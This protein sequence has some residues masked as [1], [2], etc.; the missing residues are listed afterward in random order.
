MDSVQSEKGY[1]ADAAAVG[2][3]LVG[4][5]LS[6]T[7]ASDDKVRIR[8]GATQFTLPQIRN[9][10]ARYVSE[11]RDLGLQTGDKALALLDHGPRGLFLISAASA[12]GVRLMMPY[13]IDSAALSEWLSIIRLT[14]PKHVIYQRPDRSIVETLREHSTNLVDLPFHDT[15][16]SDAEVTVDSPEPVSSFLVL[17]SSGTTGTPKAICI[18]EA[19]IVR[20]VASVSR[21]LR[22]TSESTIF[23]TG[24][25]NNT[26]GVL[27]SYGGILRGSS[28]VF[29][30]SREPENWP[31][32]IA[33]SAATHTFL[34]PVQL[35]S[36][37]AAAEAESTDL[38][39]IRKMCYG[40]ASVQRSLLERARALIPGDWLQGYGL[41]ETYGPFC[42]LEEEAI[43]SGRYLEH[44]YTVG[45]PDNTEEVRIVPV[46]G[47]PSDVGEVQVRGELMEGYMNAATGVVT[48]VGEWFHTGDLAQ[49]SPHG[50]LVLKGRMAGALLTENGY[51]IYPE[52]IESVLS[53]LVGAED[54]I[55]AAVPDPDDADEII[56]RPVVCLSGP[57]A[58][59][60]PRRVREL[61]VAELTPRLS[62]ERWP[63]YAFVT[64]DPFPK[65]DN[66]KIR[67]GELAAMVEWNAVIPLTVGVG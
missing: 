24:L 13:G 38:S 5:L 42:F 47:Y 66:G 62:R 58:D 41:T 14:Q 36:F 44:V 37:V 3:K 67:R 1:L 53:D 26:T 63:D 28:L 39:C 22:F 56:G 43:A 4:I 16:A 17:F 25:M 31:R 60:L 34:R 52:E 18:A 11:L 33:A 64:A 20:K 45:T 29:P 57:I 27:L 2:E 49:W 50:E 32:Q 19:H 61:V 54:V 10:V 35:K 9:E 59:E 7:V 30:D 65:S 12:L 40:A 8:H 15:P 46:E 48:P 55:L 21:A 51:R 6:D 23:L